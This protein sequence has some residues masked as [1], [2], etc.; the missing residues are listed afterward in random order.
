MEEHALWWLMGTNA[1]VRQ[2]LWERTVNVSFII[3]ITSSVIQP[4]ITVD[5]AAYK[6]SSIR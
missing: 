4:G 6:F 1:P 3:T 2:D 5:H